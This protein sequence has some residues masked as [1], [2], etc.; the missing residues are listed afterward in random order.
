MLESHMLGQSGRELRFENTGD[1]C[2]DAAGTLEATER[3][4]KELR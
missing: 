2:E 4:K 1:D 3:F